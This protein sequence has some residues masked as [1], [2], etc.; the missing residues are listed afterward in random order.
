M[1]NL[2]KD[3]LVNL[4]Q[5]FINCATV[6]Q[7]LINQ[8]NI[9]QD[10]GNRELA[11]IFYQ[12]AIA[13]YPYNLKIHQQ[14][15]TLNVAP[16]NDQPDKSQEYCHLGNQYSE[17]QE[18]FEAIVA[19]ETAISF[20]QQ[21][22]LAYQKLG[23][24]FINLEQW[25]TASHILEIAIYLNPDFPWNY[26]KLGE[27]YSHLEQWSQA[28][29]A[30]QQTIKLIPDFPWAYYKLAKIQTQLGEISEAIINYQQVIKLKSDAWESWEKLIQLLIQVGQYE[31]AIARCQELQKIHPQ[32]GW[33]IYIEL[34][35]ILM[36]NNQIEQGINC[37]LQA[38]SIRPYDKNSYLY[39]RG[40]FNY[41]LIKLSSQVLKKLID[42]YKNIITSHPTAIHAH[43]NLANILSEQGQLP[44]AI[45]HYKQ[46]L[47]YQLVE[48][49]PDLLL[50]NQPGKAKPNFLIIG[51]TKGGTTAL[52]RYL[53]SHPQIVPALHKE[54]SFFDNKFS[55][56]LDWYCAHFPNFTQ[57]NQPNHLLT[58]EATPNY[59]YSPLCCQRIYDCF[60]EI[61]L[62]VVLRNPIDRGISHY[63]MA[64]KI[65]IEKRDL[66]TV[67]N[68]EIKVLYN[69]SKH[70]HNSNNLSIIG[71]QLQ[72]GKN[73][74]QLGL[75]VYFLARWLEKFSKHQILILSNEE[76]SKNTDQTMRNTYQ[77]L[78]LPHY[79]LTE[80]KKFFTGN[81]Q[82]EMT[83]QQREN[84]SELLQPHNDLLEEYLGRKFYW[85]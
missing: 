13:L 79:P 81:Y 80:Y 66:S 63:Y 25:Q 31:E 21:N 37:Y 84:L 44:T 64:Q 58:G 41:K 42:F 26:Q 78:G 59:M 32:A 34:G 14:L 72:T 6:A 75:Y 23:E 9:Y 5:N 8:A 16:T 53:S 83:K 50:T 4:L 43:I 47:N 70:L 65:G 30:Y 82:N 28:K 68:Q 74:F 73:Y 11:I 60:P 12:R 69:L 24:L 33:N 36:A 46:A 52:Y 67:I 45:N 15:K 39:L 55:L 10:E 49:Y 29:Q 51:T 1:S 71:D 56:G 76:M 48:D 40:L 3:L 19:Y 2:S 85:N 77:F 62:I 35:N 17:K 20:N 18:I 57:N 22:P 38:I 54:I 7:S 61:K 27:A